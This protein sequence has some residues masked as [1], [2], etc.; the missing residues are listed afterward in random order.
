MRG[1]GRVIGREMRALF[2]VGTP[3]VGL[4]SWSPT[5]NI[6]R[7]PRWGRNQ[8]TVSE[9][10]LVAGEY[11]RQWSLGMQYG[12]TVDGADADAPPPPKPTAGE[13]LA[14]ATLKHA[15]AYGLEQ[16]SPDGN[17]SENRYNRQHFDENVSAMDW[18]DTYTAPFR[19]AIVRGG[20]A[21]V[22]YGCNAINGVPSTANPKIAAALHAWNFTGYR[23]TDG[24][25]IGG[26]SGLFKYVPTVEQAIA[27]SMREGES[28]I[29]DGNTYATHLLDALEAGALNMSSVRH[30]A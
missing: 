12:R 24:G 17:W 9:D 22:M 1:V 15:F 28:D 18:T 14:V 21:G 4:T 23:T 27:V 2:N 29:D 7:D 16:W 13:M 19:T 11:G 3:G 26:V 30:C 20:V 10:P 25:G 6:I 8:E 5:I